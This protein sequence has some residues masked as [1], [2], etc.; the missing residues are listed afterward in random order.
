MDIQV[1]GG[2]IKRLYPSFNMWSFEN[3][4]K[5]Q[6]FFYI[7]KSNGIDFGYYFNLYVRGPYSPEL[8]RDAFQIAEWKLIEPVKF[9]EEKI[10]EKYVKC[11]NSLEKHKDDIKWLELAA[12]LLLIKEI[13][14]D[15]KDEDLVSHVYKIKNGYSKQDIEIVL[16][17]L[18]SYSMVM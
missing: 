2:L 5:L 10:E 8:A 6:K 3:R 4:L 13:Y 18:K 12:T 11:I 7:L 17:N 1:L 15:K 16:K 14:P 9:Q